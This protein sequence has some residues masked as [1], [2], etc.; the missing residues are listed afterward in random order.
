MRNAL[1]DKAAILDHYLPEWRAVVAGGEFAFVTAWQART[2]DSRPTAYRWY[3]YA[4]QICT[5]D[6]ASAA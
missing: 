4:M 2:R 6:L 3:H 1:E 5:R